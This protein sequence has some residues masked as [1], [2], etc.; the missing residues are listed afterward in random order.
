VVSTD[1]RSSRSHRRLGAASVSDINGLNGCLETGQRAE[2]RSS[3]DALRRVLSEST[4]STFAGI[5][6]ACPENAT[7][8]GRTLKCV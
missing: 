3:N 8:A 4:R 1:S 5:V 2:A 7:G 6:G